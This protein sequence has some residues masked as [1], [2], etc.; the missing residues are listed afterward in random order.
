MIIGFI[1]RPKPRALSTKPEN[2]DAENYRN[3][4]PK[5]F[6]SNNNQ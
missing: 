4:N 5:I 1:V 6:K 3:N 2:Q